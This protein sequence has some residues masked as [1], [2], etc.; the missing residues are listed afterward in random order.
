MGR[1]GGMDSKTVFLDYEGPDTAGIDGLG[2]TY[3]QSAHG[4]WSFYAYLD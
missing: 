4:E 3:G 2:I 1:Y